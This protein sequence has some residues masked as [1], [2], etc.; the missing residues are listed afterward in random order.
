MPDSHGIRLPPCTVTL[1]VQEI[2][3]GLI[4]CALSD[5]LQESLKSW[6]P[7][8]TSPAA[9][10]CSCSMTTVVNLFPRA[11]AL[12]CWNLCS[13]LND[14]S[15]SHGMAERGR[16]IDLPCTGRNWWKSPQKR[17]MG[18]PPKSCAHPRGLRSCS[19]TRYS[20]RAPSML[21]SSTISSH[22]SRPLGDLMSCALRSRRRP[23]TSTAH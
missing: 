1:I 21:T 2:H 22:F 18:I 19:L 15:S 14:L 10:T 13:A 8:G 20:V 9:R 12:S 6:I 17:T 23:P 5:P 16:R 11:C 4:L 7:R 3:I